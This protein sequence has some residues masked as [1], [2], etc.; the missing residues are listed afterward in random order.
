MA[1]RY[2]ASWY[3]G[4]VVMVH[5]QRAQRALG[6]PLPPKV[7]VHHADGSTSPDAP[8]VICPDQRYHKLLHQR[9]RV[10]E[11]GGRPNTDAYCSACAQIKP[12]PEFRIRRASG[13]PNSECRKCSSSKRLRLR[14]D[15]RIKRI[16]RI[17]ADIK[18]EAQ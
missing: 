14:K 3:E 13:E 10:L 15:G 2:K 1:A 6:R 4:K 11:R 17:I 5:R 16:G 18:D 12:K 9:M 8:L 7:V